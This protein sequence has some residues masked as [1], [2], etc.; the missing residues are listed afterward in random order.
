M[1]TGQTTKEAGT[2]DNKKLEQR[3]SKMAA[4]APMLEREA[5]RLQRKPVLN[6]EQ[7]FKLEYSRMLKYNSQL[8]RRMNLQL[9]G[10]LSSRDIYALSTLMSQQREV[11]NDLRAVADMSQQVGMLYERATNPLMSDM[12][13][14]VTDVYYQL[15]KLLMETTKPKETAFA[16]AQL[17]ELVKQL[18]MGMQ[19][20]HGVLRQAIEEILIGGQQTVKTPRKKLRT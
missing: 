5:K 13:Q 20:S 1:K 3:R 18:G 19:T 17:D 7:R 16:M 6:A 11:I 12:T 8:I 10:S 2:K 15:R 4:E 14:L 9:Q